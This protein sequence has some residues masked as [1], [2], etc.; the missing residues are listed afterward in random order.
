M[1]V[2]TILLLILRIILLILEGMSASS[3]TQLIAGDAGV[4]FKELWEKLP[5]IYK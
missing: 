1:R 5:G 3:A 4:S 2:V